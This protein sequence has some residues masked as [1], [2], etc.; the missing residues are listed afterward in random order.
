MLTSV[1]FTDANG[2]STTVATT[3]GFTG[4]QGTLSDGSTVTMFP[5]SDTTPVS[6]AFPTFA[7]PLNTPIEFVEQS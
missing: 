2:N 5:V 3:V 7:I 1:I 6:P 4:A